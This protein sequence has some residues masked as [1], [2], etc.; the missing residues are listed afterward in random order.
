MHR[1]VVQKTMDF[2]V[3]NPDKSMNN[4]DRKLCFFRRRFSMVFGRIVEG[5]GGGFG[6]PWGVRDWKNKVSKLK[7]DK[8]ATWTR[9]GT[10]FGEGLGRFWEGF[11][12]VLNG[13]WVGLGVFW[14]LLAA[15]WVLLEALRLFFAAVRCFC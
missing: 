11:G 9:F 15:L 12:W 7:L 10:L 14:S 5:F 2:G 13:F 4:C 6:R 3:E 8:I 1:N